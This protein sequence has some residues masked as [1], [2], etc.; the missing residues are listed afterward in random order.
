MQERADGPPGFGAAL[1]RGGPHGGPGRSDRRTSLPF[2][3]ACGRSR[4][5]L[6]Q[7][8][9]SGRMRCMSCRAA[10]LGPGCS[11]SVTW[12]KLQMPGCFHG[13]MFHSV[14]F[15]WC[16]QTEHGQSMRGSSLHAHC[17]MCVHHVC[18]LSVLHA[19][20]A[21][22]CS[23]HVPHV[24]YMHVLVSLLCSIAGVPKHLENQVHARLGWMVS[25]YCSPASVLHSRP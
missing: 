1:A 23:M 15:S 20:T 13:V 2:G 19:C 17:T 3:H 14:M 7:A 21:C 25:N 5:Q 9:C 8:I 22:M 12:R 11:H 6:R 18:V 4:A 10:V 24:C 16:A